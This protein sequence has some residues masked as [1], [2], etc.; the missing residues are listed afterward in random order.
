MI[1]RR[2]YC[3]LLIA[4]A[5]TLTISVAA[6][7]ADLVLR[8]GTDKTHYLLDED[9]TA[10]ISLANSAAHP[11]II[12][13]SLVVTADNTRSGIALHVLRDGKVVKYLGERFKMNEMVDACDMLRLL[14]G[15]TYGTQI[16]L[17]KSYARFDLSQPGRY[18][19]RSSFRVLEHLKDDPVVLRLIRGGCFAECFAEEAETWQG[20]VVAETEFTIEKP[21]QAGA[22][23]W[24]R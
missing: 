13:A 3:A 23:R 21:E 20:V 16:S 12:P 6:P 11:L 18:Q 9:V 24:S 2:V 1:S 4:L 5:S 10:R 17:S 15:Y 19:V 14:P 22:Q 7:P 8:V